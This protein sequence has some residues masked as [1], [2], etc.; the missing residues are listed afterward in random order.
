MEQYSMS[1]AA[2]ALGVSLRT[3]TRWI[4]QQ[5]IARDRPFSDMRQRTLSRAQVEQLA[6]TH[7]RTLR[8]IDL[9]G[10]AANLGELYERMERL[11]AK[12]E[13][14]EAARS[15]FKPIPGKKKPENASS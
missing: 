4:D 11:E 1:E 9:E 12:V 8:P 15:Q 3:L 10:I 6:A 5:G 14:L 7:K 13:R 2:R